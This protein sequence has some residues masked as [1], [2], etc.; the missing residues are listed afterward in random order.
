MKRIYQVRL[1]LF[2]FLLNAGTMLHAQ[3]IAGKVVDEQQQPIIGASVVLLKTDSTYVE[4]TLSKADGTFMLKERKDEYLLKVSFVGYQIGIKRCCGNDAG[5][6]VLQSGVELEGVTVT[7]QR[8][9]V[10]NDVDRTTYNVQGDTDAKS[11][12]VI[13]ILRKVPFVTVDG[14]GNIKVNGSSNFK[15]YKNG[16]LNQN[17][18]NNAKDVLASIPAGMIKNIEVITEPGAKY[19]AEGADAILNIEINDK[20]S[21]DGVVGTAQ[22]A[23]SASGQHYGSLFLT[24]QFKKFTLGGN[25]SVQRLS[26]DGTYNSTDEEY[27]YHTTGNTYRVTGEGD[28]PGWLHNIELEGSYEFDKRNLLSLSFGGYSY[29]VDIHYMGTASLYDGNESLYSFTETLHDGRQKFFD[30]NGHIDYQHLTRRKGEALVFSYLLS[31]TNTRQQTG[32][33]YSEMENMPVDYTAWNNRSKGS[34]AEHTF[35]F[36]WERP[37]SKHHSLN[38]GVKYIFRDNDSQDRYE[39]N[40]GTDNRSDFSHRTHIA[41]AYGEWRFTSDAW[42]LRAGM[43]Y[44]YSYIDARYKDGSS[45]D[46]DKHLSDWVPSAG[47]SYRINDRNT[48]KLN[49]LSHINRPGISYLNPFVKETPEQVSMGNPSLGSTHLHNLNLSY[50]LV[51]PKLTANFSLAYMLN[52]NGIGAYNYLKDDVRYTT[53]NNSLRLRGYA[54][55]TYLRWTVSPTTSLMLNNSIQYRDLYSHQPD[56]ENKRWQWT[57]YAQTEQLLPGAVKLSLSGGR[58]ESTLNNLYNYSEPTYFYMLALSRSFLKEDRLSV[59]LMAYCGSGSFSKYERSDTHIV[60]GDYTGWHRMKTYS[61]NLTLRISYRFGSLNASVKKA[62][63]TIEN[64]DLIGRK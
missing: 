5:I 41:A 11:S 62:N 44:E 64:E 1:L 49:Y 6:I 29:N 40:D 4:G 28:N 61:R 3:S 54:F 37:L 45:P 22:A 57:F 48:L 36:D 50:M 8:Q 47:I 27:L 35:Q 19:D 23:W 18:T 15:I 51:L 9:L 20:L 16:R 12:S 2:V 32:R 39:Y 10:K 53:Y 13:E 42:N 58:N 38:T 55:N 24:T 59:R 63:K 30:F 33:T 25:Y 17:Y 56:L 26:H 60:N 21:M 34:F 14:Q 52:N 43:R 46:F 7:A 31:T